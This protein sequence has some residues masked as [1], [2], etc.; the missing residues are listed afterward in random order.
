MQIQAFTKRS[1][2][3]PQVNK[4]LEAL[5]AFSLRDLSFLLSP[6]FRKRT[7]QNVKRELAKTQR[8]YFIKLKI[9]GVIGIKQ[10]RIKQK[11]RT[12]NQIGEKLAKKPTHKT[13]SS[14]KKG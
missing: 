7:G 1:N 3:Q 8:G 9:S 5:I 11:L 6:F 12:D 4:I 13:F 14:L 10:K 2:F